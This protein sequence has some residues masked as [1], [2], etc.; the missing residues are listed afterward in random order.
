MSSPRRDDS[1]ELRGRRW[2]IGSSR[3]VRFPA[4]QVWVDER[5]RLDDAILDVLAGLDLAVVALSMRAQT[6]DSPYRWGR[7]ERASAAPRNRSC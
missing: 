2:T 7:L 3:P 6:E 1:S 4:W 5:V